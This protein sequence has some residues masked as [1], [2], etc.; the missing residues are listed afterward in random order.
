MRFN[1]ML[2]LTIVLMMCIPAFGEYYQYT[3][4]DGEAHFTDELSEVPAA[5]RHQVITHES[6]S[7]DA[8]SNQENLQQAPEGGEET[9]SGDQ[10][11]TGDQKEIPENM[12]EQES[13]TQRESLE[14]EPD[15]EDQ[16]IATEQNKETQGEIGA[17]EGG[18]E[19]DTLNAPGKQSLRVKAREKQKE[20]VSRKAELDQR[21]KEIQEEKTQLGK[22]PSDNASASEK[23]AYNV[24]ANKINE[25]VVQ[26]QKDYMI[27]EK[28]V[29]AF[30]EQVS[31][32]R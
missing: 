10:E 28:E 25:E 9:D 5:Q 6:E 16:S 17:Q 13:A 26:Y 30:N 29:D 3:D 11:Y 4:K 24:K 14:T 32:K 23:N 7:N 8:D 22:P 2:S 31:K 19:Q 18:E 12:D 21:Y 1:F 20:L 27:L 15:A